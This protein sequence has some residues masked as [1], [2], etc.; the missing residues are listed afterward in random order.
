M[1]KPSK[2]HEVP[3]DWAE[4][5]ARIRELGPLLSENAAKSE[6][7]RRV[8]DGVIDALRE[9]GAFRVAVPAQ[10]G[11]YEMSVRAMLE[12][13]AVVAEFDGGASWVTT[14]CNVNSWSNGLLSNAVRDDI[15]GNNPDALIAG[16]LSP[17]GRARKV[18]GGYRLSGT[19]HYASGVWHA[20]WSSVGLLVEDDQGQ[21]LD[22][23]MAL[24]PRSDY[25]IEDVWHVTG[26][27]GS[28]SNCIVIRDAFVPEHRVS[29]G[30]HIMSGDY[31]GDHPSSPLYRSAIVPVLCLVLVG[32]QLGFGRAALE[33]VRQKADKSIAYTVY[34][35][36][37]D[38]VAFQLQ[39]AEAAMQVETAHLHAYR[40]AAVIDEH[41]QRGEL[42]DVLTRTRTRGDCTVALRSINGALNTLLFA[43]GAGGF[44]DRSPLQRIW[45]DANVG[46]RHAVMLPEVNLEIFGKALLGVEPQSSPLI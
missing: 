27:K 31:I 19:W 2:K 20:D 34:D 11:G 26:L 32:P 29:S 42:P 39:V 21:V 1:T 10:Y 14:L 37:R 13:S 43:H 24:V 33:Y 25:E 22:Y 36:Q 3:R 45:R 30:T 35:K 18:A 23:G 28:G 5:V 12:V 8:P 7:D 16:V 46:A 38:S 40:A 17:E 41:A 4:L 44:A 15:W 9:V 6:A